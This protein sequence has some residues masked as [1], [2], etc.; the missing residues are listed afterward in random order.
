[1]YLKIYLMSFFLKSYC[2]TCNSS[3]RVFL[4]TLTLHFS[5]DNKPSAGVK[6]SRTCDSTSARNF[7]YKSPKSST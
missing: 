6:I 4:F 7:Q 1:M 5:E 3:L 2:L